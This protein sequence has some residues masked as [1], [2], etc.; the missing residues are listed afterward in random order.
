MTAPQTIANDTI[1]LLDYRLTL[2]DG[3][4]VDESGD[5]PLVFL[6]GHGQIIPGLERELLG[7][8][9]DDEKDVV[10]APADAYGE[11]SDDEFEV[12]PRTAFPADLELEIGQALHLRDQ[13]SG[14]AY[15]AIVSELKEKEVV[16][17]FN[18]PLAGEPLHF[19][20]KVAGLR[21][22]TA[23]ELEHGFAQ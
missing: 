15:Q 18:H 20:V 6:Q 21:A 7:M 1:V 8:A 23:E 11:Y 10:V 17:D 12:M 2:G 3:E 22:A 5:Q 14:Q 9:V 16:L 4:I 19:W 13:N